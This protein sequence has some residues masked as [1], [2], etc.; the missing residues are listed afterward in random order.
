MEII[1]A[2]FAYYL[3]VFSS[4][5][6]LGTARVLWIV[7]R[8]GTRMSELLEAPVM[9]LV[10]I[11]AARWVVRHLAVRPTRSARIGLGFV[12]LTLLLVSEFGLVLWLRGMTIREYFASR[13]RVSGTVYYILLGL[14]AVVPLL[15]G[16]YEAH[17]R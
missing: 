4:G 15:V 9:L 12:A 2:G 10:T 13:D 14:V 17:P 16:P 3:L 6:I 5:F 8:L 1:R 7:P 11:V